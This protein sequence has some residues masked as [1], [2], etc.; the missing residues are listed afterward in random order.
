MA[1]IGFGRWLGDPQ[2]F[3][4]GSSADPYR[5]YTP[6]QL[7]SVRNDLQGSYKLMAD[8]DMT[9]WCLLRGWIP[10]GDTNNPFI[11]D[12]NGNGHT[13]SNISQARAPRVGGLFGC[14]QKSE[15]YDLTIDAFTYTSETT[16]FPPYSYG[17]GGL[18]ATSK[19]GNYIHG[20]L[21]T[22]SSLET[23]YGTAGGIVGYAG[24]S[25]KDRYYRCGA[26]TEITASLGGGI[27]GWSGSN[28]Q[29][30]ECYAVAP[31]TSTEV[32]AGGIAGFWQGNILRYCYTQCEVTGVGFC[33][34]VCGFT[35]PGCGVLV[36]YSANQVLGTTYSG[37]IGGYG[38]QSAYYADCLWD[39]TIN[40]TL[41]DPDNTGTIGYTT[42]EMKSKA[43]YLGLGWSTDI[44]AINDGSYPTLQW[45]A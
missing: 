8:L 27:V 25:D 15:I 43:T 24:S 5:I 17:A 18:A 36:S 21:I 13:I 38:A 31:V 30:E 32:L 39:K 14:I 22:D 1:H 26:D 9:D 7:Y 44:W 19:G 35:A 37:G 29:I 33:G 2:E 41:P 6:Q 11:G 28:D 12:F 4:K 23:I 3:G 45:Q 34:G 16:V 40:K 10:I 20:I 42:A